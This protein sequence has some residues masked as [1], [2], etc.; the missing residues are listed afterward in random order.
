MLLYLFDT[1]THHCWSRSCVSTSGITMSCV[2]VHSSTV[3]LISLLPSTSLHKPCS[4]ELLAN[5]SRSD[6]PW[7]VNGP[8]TLFLLF[9]R[10]VNSPLFH[11]AFVPVCVFFPVCLT[12]LQLSLIFTPALVFL[13]WFLFCFCVCVCL[14]S[15]C[16][17]FRSPLVLSSLTLCSSSSSP[18]SKVSQPPPVLNSRGRR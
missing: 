13:P 17:I 9:A 10:V 1:P 6:I 18:H 14:V 16:H 3:L 7:A 5:C 8:V 11:S 2:L 15:F 12:S 4:A